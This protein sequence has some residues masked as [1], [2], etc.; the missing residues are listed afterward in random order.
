[1]KIIKEIE[2]KF[3]LNEKLKLNENPN[4]KKKKMKVI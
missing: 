1:M 4:E 3:I 2:R